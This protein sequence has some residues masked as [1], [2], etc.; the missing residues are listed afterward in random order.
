VVDE[1]IRLG[2]HHPHVLNSGGPEHRA[3]ETIREREPACIRPIV[4]DVLFVILDVALERRPQAQPV[5]T[6]H[7]AAVD[8]GEPGDE[9]MIGARRHIGGAPQ[10]DDVLFT[11][12]SLRR[13]VGSREASEE[14]VERSVLLHEEDD[15]LDLPPSERD[16]VLGGQL[17]DYLRPHAIGDDIGKGPGWSDGSLPLSYRVARGRVA[18]GTGIA[19]A[20]CRG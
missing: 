18:Y 9:G 10:R 4:G 7:L 15:V 14:V 5:E 20:A 19:P 16:R 13:P 3:E 6:V 17:L 8:R 2:G 12:L 1:A 11:G